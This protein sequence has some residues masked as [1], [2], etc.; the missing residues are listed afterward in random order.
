MSLLVVAPGQS[1]NEPSPVSF[2]GFQETLVHQCCW[3][4]RWTAQRASWTYLPIKSFFMEYLLISQNT[5]WKTPVY[6]I[7]LLTKPFLHGYGSGKHSP[8]S[9]LN[10]QQVLNRQRQIGDIL[11]LWHLFSVSSSKVC[12]GLPVLWDVSRKKVSFAVPATKSCHGN[13]P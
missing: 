5:V 2:W 10:L 4:P 7:N 1:W 11:P 3:S 6:S 13:S 9:G 8:R 12:W